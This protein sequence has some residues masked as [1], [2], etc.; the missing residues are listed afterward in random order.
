MK[1]YM[2]YRLQNPAVKC[3]LSR[4]KFPK[5]SRSTHTSN[6]QQN[7]CLNHIMLCVVLYWGFQV[8]QGTS[9]NTFS[10]STHLLYY[11][12]TEV[13]TFVFFNSLLPYEY[14]NCV[15]NRKK[16]AYNDNV[17]F[18]VTVWQW[19][20]SLNVRNVLYY[21]TFSVWLLGD[22]SVSQRV[23]LRNPDD[24][25][26]WLSDKAAPLSLQYYV[27]KLGPLHTNLHCQ[28]AQR[29][30]F[31]NHKASQGWGGRMKWVRVELVPGRF[32]IQARTRRKSL[33]CYCSWPTPCR[34]WWLVCL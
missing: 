29:R 12:V 17:T 5:R 33:G 11:L 16:Q 26:L 25:T 14:R 18:S 34:K 32:L 3:K 1:C 15:E 10:P 27:N 13:L 21:K 8:I 6:S 4:Q 2:C 22:W 28:Q 24:A 31:N 23:L 19:R 9:V 7:R 30:Y 20:V